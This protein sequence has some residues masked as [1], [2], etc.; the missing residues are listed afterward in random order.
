MAKF[1]NFAKSIISGIRVF[2]TLAIAGLCTYGAMTDPTTEV[3]DAVVRTVVL[4]VIWEAFIFA[5]KET[6]W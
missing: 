6:E 3:A 5:I 4:I 1:T 2:G